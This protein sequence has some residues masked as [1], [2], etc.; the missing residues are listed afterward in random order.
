MRPSHYN[1]RVLEVIGEVG[2]IGRPIRPRMRS[3]DVVNR[4][5]VA[6]GSSEDCP[7]PQFQSVCIAVSIILIQLQQVVSIVVCDRSIRGK[8]I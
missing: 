2:S 6:V 1:T 3:I 8:V 4:I 7:E 5:S